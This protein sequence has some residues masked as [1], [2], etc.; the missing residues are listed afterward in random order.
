MP[1]ENSFSCTDHLESAD[2]DKPSATPTATDPRGMTVKL[3]APPAPIPRKEERGDVHIDR[4]A[5]LQLLQDHGILKDGQV[6]EAGRFAAESVVALAE[7]LIGEGWLTRFQAQQLLRHECPRLVIGPYLLLDELGQGGMGQIFKAQ[8]RRLH[9]L[10]ALK[11]IRTECLGSAE[12]VARFQRE[13]RAAARLNH[14]NIV[15]LYDANVIDDVHFLALEYVPG[16][17]LH[18]RV[19]KNGPLSV[20]D[21]CECL[22]QVASG[23]QHAFEMGMVHRDIKPSNFLVA[24]KASLQTTD[25]AEEAPAATPP[26]KSCLVKILDMGLAR[27]IEP[28]GEQDGG[29]TREGAVFGTPDFIAPEQARNAR[30]ADIRSDLYSLGCTAYFLL[31]GRPPFAEGTAL[32]KLLMHQLDE[33]PRLEKLRPDVPEPLVA[34]VR[35]LM[36]KN[37]ADRYARPA[38]LLHALASAGRLRLVANKQAETPRTPTVPRIAELPGHKGWVTALAF[39]PD[40]DQLV[41]AGMD[42]TVRLWGFSRHLPPKITLHL[43]GTPEVH[44][45]AF[46]PRGNL[47]AAGSGAHD[48]HIGLWKLPTEE[49]A[50]P[51]TLRGHEAPIDILAFSADGRLLASG[52]SDKTVRLWDVSGRRPERW[53]ALKGAGSAIKAVAFSPDGHSL[54][55]G[56]Q[57]GALH[58]WNLGTFWNTQRAVLPAH[59][60]GVA[61][62]VYAPDGSTL[63]TGGLDQRIRLWDLKGSRPHA[64]KLEGHAAVVCCVQFSADGRWL[65]SV[66]AQGHVICWNAVTGKA[67]GAWQLTLSTLA[68]CYTW[69]ADAR[70]VAMGRS[71]GEINIHRLPIQA[72]QTQA[73][74]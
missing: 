26:L 36:A 74:E 59:D 63:A 15:T 56:T 17:D 5:F 29:I 7:M 9:R 10:V 27:L 16:I 73:S 62:V 8:H 46:S 13:A 57:G 19:K 47:L 41:S 51:E 67:A 23:L 11:L 30:T 21:T 53:G 4:T 64:T 25:T 6:D 37:P 68:C 32:E 52:S 44:A 2:L 42:G 48:S 12:T 69:T 20:E 54:A 3:D 34:I 55:A 39:S 45:V 38:D 1:N 66:D 33:P 24:R 58:L 61:T 49:T 50:T 60:G 70:Y 40:R 43:R 72:L 18:Q 35:K 22:R 31:T 14:P 71:N 28:E 65:V